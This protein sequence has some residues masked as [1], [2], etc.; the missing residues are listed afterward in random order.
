MP[1]QSTAGLSQLITVDTA[2]GDY[3]QRK[4]E[5]DSE[6][7]SKSAREVYSNAWTPETIE[8]VIQKLDEMMGTSW[9]M[10]DE[11]DKHVEALC[12]KLRKQELLVDQLKDY[13]V[14]LKQE[15]KGSSIGVH[16][17]Y[18]DFIFHMKDSIES[19]QAFRDMALCI[20]NDAITTSGG[21]GSR[22]RWHRTRKRKGKGRAPGECRGL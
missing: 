20:R 2:G 7:H 15:L 14:T 9:R 3:E 16:R 12:E 17:F 5:G 19:V 6:G 10:K 22:R 4:E 18:D 1:L 11:H 13:T 21:N 8:L